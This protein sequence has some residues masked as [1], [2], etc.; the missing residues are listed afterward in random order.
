MLRGSGDSSSAIQ[1]ILDTLNIK[2]SNPLSVV[3][4]GTAPALT[5]AQAAIRLSA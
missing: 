3:A 1:N 2:T 5:D 4:S